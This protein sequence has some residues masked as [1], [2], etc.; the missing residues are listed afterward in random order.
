MRSIMDDLFRAFS[1]LTRLPMPQVEDDND[2]GYARCVWAYPLIGAVIGAFSALVWFGGQFA[3]LGLSLSAGLVIAVQLLLTGAMHED[4]IADFADGV[5]GGQDRERRLAIMRDSR[6]GTF[7]VVALIVI[8][9]LRWSA[10]TS[11][12]LHMVLAGLICSALIGR[13]VMAVLPGILAPARE[14]GLGMLVAGP[15]IKSLLVALLISAAVL[16]LHLS[17][18][19]AMVSIIAAIVAAGW[20]AMLAKRSIGGYTGDVLGAAGLAAETAALLVFATV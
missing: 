14:E 16:F 2:K 3:G 19:I 13:L 4:G 20:I 5:G 10:I 6:I 15:S 7:G 1:L 11:L 12:G 8:I 18:L 17:S 9:G